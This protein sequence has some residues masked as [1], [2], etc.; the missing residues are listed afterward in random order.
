M[1]FSLLFDYDLSEKMA[2]ENSLSDSRWHLWKNR[3]ILLLP[4]Y[5]KHYIYCT[6]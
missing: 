5:T 1:K 2:D 6:L 4:R 3:N